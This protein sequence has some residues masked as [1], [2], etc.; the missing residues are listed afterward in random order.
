MTTIFLMA[1]EL[2]FSR[3][4]IFNPILNYSIIIIM[5][6]IV[7]SIIDTDIVEIW[8]GLTVAT[9]QLEIWA[10]TIV[11]QGME[12]CHPVIPTVDIRMNYMNQ[13][14]TQHTEHKH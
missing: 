5:V 14:N 13:Q 1:L 6:I 11:I 9:R 2:M 7:G 4:L 12:K 10:V 8:V 3:F